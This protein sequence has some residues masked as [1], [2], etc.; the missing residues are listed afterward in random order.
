MKQH[1]HNFREFYGGQ[2]CDEDFPVSDSQI[3]DEFVRLFGLM[4]VLYFLE[5]RDI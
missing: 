4:R 5:S 1:W 3:H 2:A